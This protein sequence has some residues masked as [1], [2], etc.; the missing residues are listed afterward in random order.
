MELHEAILAQL[1]GEGCSEVHGNWISGFSINLG[2]CTLVKA[3]LLT[4]KQGLTITK[5]I[6]FPKIIIHMDSQ[7]NKV[8][9]LLLPNQAYY[10]DFKEWQSMLKDSGWTVKLK[11]YFRESNKTAD[12]LAN[13]GIEQDHHIPLHNNPPVPLFSI[14]FEDNC[15]VAWPRLISIE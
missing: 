13:V 10:H 14:L 11:H 6:G 4:L 1:E 12:F 8:I 9:E 7:L 15:T 2:R 3:E 5:A